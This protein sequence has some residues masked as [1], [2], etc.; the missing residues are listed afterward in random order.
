M[1][2]SQP[3][4][5][6]SARSSEVEGIH[7]EN[8][9]AWLAARTE[10]EDPLQFD[11][12]AGGRSNMTYTVTDAS[13]R[14]FVLRRPPM[15][16]LLPS[17]HDM[18][19]EHRLM[20]ALR[21]GPV[22]VPLMVG[23][24]QDADVNE[25]DFYIMHFLEGIVVRDVEIGR[26]IE[27]EART[28]M[29]HELVNTLCAL[30][31]VDID[32]V[33][34]GDL[35]KRSGY[36]ERQLKRWSGQWEQSKT[37]EIPLIDKVRD[38]L[39]ERL[40]QETVTTIAHG[41]YRLSNCMMDPSGP[42]A[43]VLDWELCTLGDPM[44]DLAG[45]LGYWHDPADPEARGDNETT[46]LEGFLDQEEMAGLYAEEMGVDLS[47]V[48]YYRGFASWRLACIGE[49][50]YARYLNGQQGSQ[51]EELDLDEYKDSVARR[52]DVAA[53]FLGITV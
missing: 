33:G 23:L 17:A 32:D 42:V 22:P 24:C 39:G 1:T 29:S 52:V 14:R 7:R 34:L 12:I 21:D 51:G 37:R 41:D 36:I 45:L 13:G 9:T 5:G 43:G 48:D 26:T 4:N 10:I 30:H 46:G 35:A 40:P 47:L 19:R 25:R 18:A 15:G 44:A 53:A 8:V 3:T 31:R 2:T 16:K 50:V 11:L 28:R 38:T 49:G 6:Q 20:H 27:V